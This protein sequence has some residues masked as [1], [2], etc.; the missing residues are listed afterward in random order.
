MNDRG[1]GG[2]RREISRRERRAAVFLVAVGVGLLAGLL[3]YANVR[4]PLTN[5]NSRIDV[6]MPVVYYEHDLSG[7][8][9]L[10][11]SIDL[12]GEPVD[13][14]ILGRGSFAVVQ[15]GGA[16]EDVSAQLRLTD[17]AG[18]VE[19]RFT[20]PATDEYYVVFAS[21]CTSQC[22]PTSVQARLWVTMGQ[23]AGMPTPWVGAA[24]AAVAA[25]GA[26]LLV[27]RPWG[28]LRR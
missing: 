26:V 6:D 8:D 20:A 23:V 15:Q 19:T 21:S 16:S 3:V 27:V 2:R 9:T 7:G 13:I 12:D 17:R 24:S 25:L 18:R 4:F 11:F 5:Y 22:E 28:R 14:L 10:H 1:S